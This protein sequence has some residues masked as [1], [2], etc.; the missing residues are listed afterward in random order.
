MHQVRPE[1]LSQAF[2]LFQGAGVRDLQQ[3]I[4]SLGHFE[5]LALFSLVVLGLGR[6]EEHAQGTGSQ[7]RARMEKVLP[8][9]LDGEDAEVV[10]LAQDI[11]QAGKAELLPRA[12]A[13]PPGLTN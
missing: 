5:H 10:A 8:S 6:Q 12:A 3:H 1:G 13:E 9:S 11:F 4:Q 2:Q 7:T